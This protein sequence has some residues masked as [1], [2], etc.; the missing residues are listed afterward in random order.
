M[1]LVAKTDLRYSS[2]DLKAGERFE[3]G[4]RDAHVLTVSG[5]A[6][7]AGD[8]GLFQSK[9]ESSAGKGRSRYRRSD[10]RAED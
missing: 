3:A 2:R 1:Q 4:D 5:K 8:A 7:P 6:E 9:E 10:M